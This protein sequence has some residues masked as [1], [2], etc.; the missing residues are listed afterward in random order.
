AA[1]DQH[2]TD[3]LGGPGGGRDDPD[4][5][6]GGPDGGRQVVLV[7]H[8]HPVELGAD[9][10]GRDVHQGDDPETA[11]G[12]EVGAAGQRGAQAADADEH[13]R[14]VSGGTDLGADLEPQ[15]FHVVTDPA[16]PVRTEV[17]QV[18]AQLGGVDPGRLGELTGAD[19]G[20]TAGGVVVEGAQ[21][22][23][24]PGDGRLRDAAA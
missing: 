13:H 18:L 14:P 22:T 5:G 2:V 8:G 1:V 17:R 6:A 3:A 19:G 16:D 20:H 11:T 23:G 7:G 15:E 21:V 4:G 9:D 12:A 10:A 24:Q